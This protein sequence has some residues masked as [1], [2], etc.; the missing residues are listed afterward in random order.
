[1]KKILFFFAAVCVMAMTAISLTSCDKNDSSSSDVTTKP[2]EGSWYCSSAG[3][4]LSGKA[5]CTC[6]IT[7]GSI[8][9][10]SSVISSGTG[11]YSYTLNK[12]ISSNST[13]Y[14]KTPNS[15]TFI[16]KVNSDG[17]IHIGSD[18]TIGIV[19]T[20]TYNPGNGK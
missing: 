4:D 8:T 12:D 1:M 9:V 10:Q 16:I 19:V 18:S 20:G 11:T 15:G 17:T 14:L 3:F 6:T 13:Y 2:I 5:A 7:A